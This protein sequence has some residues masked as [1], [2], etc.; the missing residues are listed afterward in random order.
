MM[1]AAPSVRVVAIVPSNDLPVAVA[2]WERLGFMRT[3]GDDQ[4][5]IMTGWDC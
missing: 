5:V 2:F 4:Y 1:A 3:G